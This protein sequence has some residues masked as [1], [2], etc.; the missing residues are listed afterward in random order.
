MTGRDERFDAYLRRMADG[1]VAND[2]SCTAVI[3]DVD[4]GLVFTLRDRVGRSH[5]VK[6]E[7]P[8]GLDRF[9]ARPRFV[10]GAAPR[11]ISAGLEDAFTRFVARHPHPLLDF[12]GQDIEEIL[13][14]KGVEL[15]EVW[16]TQLEPG[17]TRWSSFVLEALELRNG[18]MVLTFRDG[19]QAV[20]LRLTDRDDPRL[21]GTE[22]VL[23]VRNL[24]LSLVED[25]RTRPI[26][27]FDEVERFLAYLLVHTTGPATRI[28][29]RAETS[30][31]VTLYGREVELNQFLPEG[32]Q[33]ASGMS[34]ALLG[35]KGKRLKVVSFGDASCRQTFPPLRRLPFFDTW[36]YF[37]VGM[38]ADPGSWVA[39]DF[40]EKEVVGG[41][42][43]QLERLLRALKDEDRDVKVALVQT[44]VSRLIGDDVKGVLRKV[45]GD[46]DHLVLD[47]DFQAKDTAVD[48]LV[49]PWVLRAFRKPARQR[50]N[51]VNLVGLGDR[52][53]R[54]TSE[55][56]R[57]LSACGVEVNACLFPSFREDE[58]ERFDAAPLT[59]SSTCSIVQSAFRLAAAKGG[60]TRWASADPPFGIEG[61]R[62]WVETVIRE[63]E[64]RDGRSAARDFLT[65]ACRDYR[66]QLEPVREA[67]RDTSIAIVASS[68]FSAF[69][70]DPSEIFGIR[71][72]DLLAELGLNVEIFLHRDIPPSKD[73]TEAVEGRGNV[74]LNVFEEPPALLASVAASRSKLLLTSIRRNGPVLALGKVPVFAQAF[75]MG[76]DGALRTAQR[77]AE[78]AGFDFV[79]RYGKYIRR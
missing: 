53:F 49:W 76:F 72:L 17:R 65:H 7:Y 46:N 10:R 35:R 23:F 2:F 71:I 48:A 28:R 6:L 36:S 24:A 20:G 1:L 12:R 50:K 77:L 34:A 55:I 32:R 74:T 58:L 57:V 31:S 29:G 37:P 43:E 52:F 38:A 5:V 30:P 54:S 3:P 15:Q 21:P 11:V 67:L 60:R 47:P 13:L 14:K 26:L 61:T 63:L 16:R 59:V 19:A 18:A 25:S 27:P 44:C 9:E 33:G 40:S 73:L 70:H 8:E 51:L 41:S 4:G 78:Y 62:T 45:L 66:R 56:A 42:E 69:V 68:R 79:R 75:E 64:G 22:K 39:F